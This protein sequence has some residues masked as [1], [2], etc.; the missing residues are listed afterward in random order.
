MVIIND[1][2]TKLRQW[3]KQYDKDCESDDDNNNGPGLGACVAVAL[4]AV[5]LIL[6][7]EI[8]LPVLVLAKAT[9]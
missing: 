4:I 1:R 8:T 3:E 9:Q 6:A 5:G 2:D 7:P